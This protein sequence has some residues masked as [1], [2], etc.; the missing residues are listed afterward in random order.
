VRFGF[1]FHSQGAICCAYN[2]VDAGWYV[3]E[4]TVVIGTPVLPNPEDFE[5]GISDW[6]VDR[7]TWE[8]GV[9]TS[10]PNGAHSGVKCG[11]TVLAH[12]YSEG[13]SSRLISAPFEVPP[14]A[15]NPRLRFWHWF[16]F[17]AGDSGTVQIKQGTNAWQTLSGPYTGSGGGIWSPAST[18]DLSAYAG[19]QVQLGFWFQS[20]GVIC[21]SYNDVD[22][23]WF[24]D[25]ICIVRGSLSVTGIPPISGNEETTITFRAFATGTNASSLLHFDLGQ[26][27]P[28][29]SAMNP[30]TGDFSWTPSEGQ[31]PGT[32]LIPVNC[33]DSGN[34]NQNAC[35]FVTITVNEV[36][37]APMMTT[38]NHTFEA[39]QPN[40]FI[41]CGTDVDIPVNTLTYMLIKGPTGLTVA[42][43]GHV[44][45]TPTLGQVGSTNVTVKVTDNNPPA[46]N[47]KQ[48]SATN[49]FTI[50]VATNSIYFLQM[51]QVSGGN[52]EFTIVGGRSGSNYM[53]QCA[54]F[55]LDCSPTNIWQDIVPV[56]ATSMPFTFGYTVPNFVNTTNRFYRLR[57]Q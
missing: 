50:T 55:V 7:G 25:D 46:V 33:I 31:G 14:L 18:I 28:Q 57:T 16:S 27:A 56:Q 42:S 11:G 3:D 34:D 37:K 2:D 21:C 15:E 53:L 22:A 32:Y 9:P 12:N 52:F 38:T 5:L 41:L 13:V 36:N 51:R 24:V 8:V 19:T 23:G 4:V 44:N 35:I 54:P 45:W 43:D 6:S 48:L 26:R 40:S 1:Y 10:G 17:N 39:G 47:S 20:Q 49:T 29:G 30:I